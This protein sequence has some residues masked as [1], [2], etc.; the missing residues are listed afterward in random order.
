[1][2]AAAPG[3]RNT[4]INKSAMIFHL[5]DKM[6]YCQE[7]GNTKIYPH[8][9]KKGKKERQRKKKMAHNELLKELKSGIKIK[10]LF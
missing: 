3:T 2:L 6:L 5:R 9:Q 8:P 10:L 7:I 4:E 1:M